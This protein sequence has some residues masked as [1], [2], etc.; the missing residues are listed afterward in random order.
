MLDRKR[1]RKEPH[2]IEQAIAAKNEKAKLDLWTAADT[3]KRSLMLQVENLRNTRN[4]LSRTVAMKKRQGE[5]AD[6]EVEESRKTGEELSALEKRLSVLD[7]ELNAMELSFPNVPDADVPVGGEENNI[8]MEEG[9]T[10]P[11]FQ[12]Q[13]RPHWELMENVFLPAE[14]GKITGSNF[15][16]FRG[17]AARLQRTLISW[18]LDTHTEN[19][20][21]EVWPPFL[22]NRDSMTA[23]AQLPKMEDDMYEIARDGLFLI[24]T[25]EV[26]ITNL[27]RNAMLE[28]SELPLRLCG[29]TPCFRREAGS[30]GKDTRGLNRVHQFEKVEM[31]RFEHP[32]RSDQAHM[33]MVKHVTGMLD[34]LELPWRILLLAT[35]D[36]SFAAARCY[37]IE[38]WSA[39][40]EKWLEVSSVSNF[41]DFQARRGSVRF[42]PAGGGKPQFVHTLNGSGLALPRLIAALVENHQTEDGRMRL[43]EALAVRMGTEI[44]G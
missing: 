6:L 40:Q 16:L 24:P 20:M 37:D 2:L 42:K 1:L 18:M 35:G 10:M 8:V 12:F 4:E 33:E 17:W 21:E 43:P 3:E 36:L 13:P 26:P 25:G 27:Y 38:I 41:R 44:L 34:E 39:G 31:V 14:S 23:T 5:N 7:E 9:G 22:A 32:D 30:Y 29:Y 28:E 15:I 11:S 19:G